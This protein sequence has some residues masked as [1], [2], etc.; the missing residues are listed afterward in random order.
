LIGAA[1]P[2]FAHEVAAAGL[3]GR[4]EVTGFLSQSRALEELSQCSILVLAGPRDDAALTQGHVVAKV[5]EYLASELPILYVGNLSADVAEILR[6]Q[7]GCA[8]HRPDDIEGIKASISS[9]QG[10]RF[11][12]D[13]A[14]MSRRARAGA[15]AGL[16]NS[17]AVSARH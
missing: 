5:W 14:G 13:V 8:E 4:L 10:R 2:S 15:L 17:V 11:S 6:S 16:L 1:N 7:P 12:R 3:E 9:L